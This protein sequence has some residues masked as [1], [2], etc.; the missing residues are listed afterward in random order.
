M[1]RY[2]DNC[3]V[4]VEPM[5]DQERRDLADERDAEAWQ[6]L[7]DAILAERIA[8]GL[9]NRPIVIVAEIDKRLRKAREDAI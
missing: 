6:A 5:N 1:S 7:Y 4:G 9:D 3:E 8:N 2:V